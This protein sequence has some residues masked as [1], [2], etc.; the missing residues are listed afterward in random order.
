MSSRDRNLDYR[1]EGSIFGLIFGRF[2]KSATNVYPCMA[3][4]TRR[5]TGQLN[6]EI[7]GSV[8]LGLAFMDVSHGAYRRL[9]YNV[10]YWHSNRFSELSFPMCSAPKVMTREGD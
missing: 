4:A 1:A 2:Q 10:F 8:A 6:R 5:N 7:A 3:F 9:H